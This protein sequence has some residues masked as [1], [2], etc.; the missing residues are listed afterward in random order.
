MSTKGGHGSS[1]IKHLDQEGAADP[2]V[3]DSFFDRVEKLEPMPCARWQTM[4]SAGSMPLR[5]PGKVA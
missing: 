2:T 1:R 5:S 3:W 4:P